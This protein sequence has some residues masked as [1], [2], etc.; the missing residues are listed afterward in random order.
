[1]NIV[2][3]QGNTPSLQG[4]HQ[5]RKYSMELSVVFAYSNISFCK[6]SVVQYGG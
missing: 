6:T 1:M 4:R 2:D 5:Q 3:P